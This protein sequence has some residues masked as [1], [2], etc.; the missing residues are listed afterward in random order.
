MLLSQWDSP[1]LPKDTPCCLRTCSMFPTCWMETKDA[2]E[3]G[4]LNNPLPPYDTLWYNDQP[5]CMYQCVFTA[6]WVNISWKQGF[7]LLVMFNQLFSYRAGLNDVTVFRVNSLEWAKLTLLGNC[8]FEP[9]SLVVSHYSERY[10]V[11]M[12]SDCF[13]ECY[14]STFGCDK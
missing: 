4:S 1:F 9:K 8:S 7:P 13:Y 5:S 6:V 12:E 10:G 14:E 11:E 2:S 3:L